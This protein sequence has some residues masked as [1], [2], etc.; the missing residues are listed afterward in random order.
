[1]QQRRERHPAR[2]AGASRGA[3]PL[4]VLARPSA[5]HPFRAR[6]DALCASAA[7]QLAALPP[8]PFSTFDAL[9]PDPTLLP[10]VGRVFTGPHDPRPTLHALDAHLRALG[11]PPADRDAW[12]G[13]L[14][15]RAAALAVN[16][17]QDQAALAADAPSFIKSVHAAA[18]TFR[19]AA[20]A[21]TVFGVGRCV[22]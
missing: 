14:A 18:R 16:D 2:R 21:A 20:I 15:A 4:G 5:D 17:E 12:R 11:Q 22:L 3:L 9:H 13:V 7:T 10:A 19:A 1:M 8:F 6:A